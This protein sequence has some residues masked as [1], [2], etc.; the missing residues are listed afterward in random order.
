MSERPDPER[1]VPGP[2]V[3]PDVSERGEV[4]V[5]AP[6]NAAA[7]PKDAANVLLQQ[8]THAPDA[9]DIEDPDRQL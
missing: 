8:G 3:T 5:A 7:R 2:T 1:S 4:P 9:A 6:E